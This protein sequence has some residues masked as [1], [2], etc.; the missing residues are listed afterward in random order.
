MSYEILMRRAYHCGRHGAR[1]ADADV[2]RKMERAFNLLTAENWLE[3]QQSRE[4]NYAKAAN[5]VANFVSNAITKSL[6]E[7]K[8]SEKLTKLQELR[9]KIAHQ[10]DKQ[11]ID[12]VID[13]VLDIFVELNLEIR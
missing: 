8:D 5:E 2:Y 4:L 3:P 10:S 7:I 12:Q 13:E 6:S 1:G 11:I 9:Q